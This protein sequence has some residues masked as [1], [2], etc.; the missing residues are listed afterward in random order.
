VKADLSLLAWI[1]DTLWKKP[2]G[3]FAVANDDIATLRKHLRRFLTVADPE[4]EPMYFRFYDPRILAVFLP[5]C[6]R[7]EQKTFMGPIKAY[8]VND[9]MSGAITF[10]LNIPD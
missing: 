10:F 2:W 1:T 4:G 9:L 3:V 6:I 8:A 5:T 7:E